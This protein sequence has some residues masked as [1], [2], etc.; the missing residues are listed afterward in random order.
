MSK[1]IQLVLCH[2]RIWNHICQSPSPCPFY[3]INQPPHIQY[4]TSYIPR[5]IYT[6][7]LSAFSY[8][9]LWRMFLLCPHFSWVNDGRQ[10]IKW[11]IIR[12]KIVPRLSS[13]TEVQKF[14]Q[15]NHSSFPSSIECSLRADDVLEVMLKSET[16]K[17]L[18][19]LLAMLFKLSLIEH[20]LGA[21][22][23]TSYVLIYYL[24]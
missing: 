15:W 5:A 24:I 1:V 22:Y 17:T 16:A 19:A 23:T 6:P 2:G 9:S 4:F 12:H 7:I 18:R 11:G 10:I 8:S 13:K 21:R 20:L 3:S 14:Q